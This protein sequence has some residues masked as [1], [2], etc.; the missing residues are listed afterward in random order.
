MGILGCRIFFTA[1]RAFYWRSAVW[2]DT[3]QFLLRRFASDHARATRIES[4]LSC[5]VTRV[6]SRAPCRIRLGGAGPMSE[7][8]QVH[9]TTL[10]S[11]RIRPIT[12]PP[13][14]SPLPSSWLSAPPS[15]PVPRLPAA[16]RA[17]HAPPRPAPLRPAPLPP[18]PAVPVGAV[19]GLNPFR[20][21]PA[22]PLSLP[23][24]PSPGRTDAAPSSSRLRRATWRRWTG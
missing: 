24:N 18:P 19:A 3:N 9:S 10:G 7:R 8:C 5:H 17:T 4:W 16:C 1:W 15:S 20:L 11:N 6:S 14:R 2:E 21:A 23:P 22:L 12:P 13:S